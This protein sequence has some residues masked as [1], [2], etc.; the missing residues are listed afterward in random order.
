M[1]ILFLVN[2]LLAIGT[3][4]SQ[5]GILFLVVY[6]M[7]F[8][9][10]YKNISDFIGKYGI[11]LVFIISLVATCG[12]LFYSQVMGFAPCELCWFQRVCLFPLVIISG[13]ALIKKDNNII[14][15]ALS[16]SAVG[17]LIAFYQNY[18]GFSGTDSAC[19]LGGGVS[20]VKRYIFEF[21]YITIPLIALTGFAMIIIFLIFAKNYQNEKINQ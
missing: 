10:K 6:F 17:F 11:L 4:L 18:L 8:K 14:D 1:D 12:S 5:I 2:K 15:Y 7:F 19:P 9:D 21:G 3:V 16:L 13:L 20:C